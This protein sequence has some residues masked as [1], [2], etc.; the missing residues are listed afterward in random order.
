MKTI[1]IVKLIQEKYEDLP[2]IITGNFN[3]EE[4]HK[5]MKA[6]PDN[7]KKLET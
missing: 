4:N 5:S 7:I 1:E 6:L 3:L 2:L